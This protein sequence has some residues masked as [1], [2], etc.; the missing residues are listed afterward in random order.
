[1]SDG[2]AVHG[3]Q[4]SAGCGGFDVTVRPATSGTICMGLRCL[5]WSDALN[6]ATAHLLD[7]G[8]G[9]SSSRGVTLSDDGRNLCRSQGLRLTQGVSDVLGLDYTLAQE[10]N[11]E[12]LSGAARLRGSGSG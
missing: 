11:S 10:V 3:F 2:V 7:V 4:P 1:M 5:A 6:Y 9:P 8:R 12:P